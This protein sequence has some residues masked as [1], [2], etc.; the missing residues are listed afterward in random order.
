MFSTRNQSHNIVNQV[1]PFLNQKDEEVNAASAKCVK[2]EENNK[3]LQK[4]KNVLE[5]EIAAI[6]K[7]NEALKN[8]ITAAE[9]DKKN[10]ELEYQ[11]LQ[12]EKMVLESKFQEKESNATLCMMKKIIKNNWKYLPFLIL[13]PVVIICLRK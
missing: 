1:Q 9:N 7:K 6:E 2:L 3:M 11:K 4:E 13:P 8:E 5:D 12:H 10:L